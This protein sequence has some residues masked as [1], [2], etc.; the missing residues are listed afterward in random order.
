LRLD[1]P[2]DPQRPSL[3]TPLRQQPAR[4][5]SLAIRVKGDAAAYAPRL[6]DVVRSID[7]DTPAYWVRTYAQVIREATFDTRLLAGLFAAFGMLALVLAA[8][9][10]Y[11]VIAFNI[12]QRTREIGVRRALGA[13]SVSVLRGVLARTGWQLGVGIAG[14]LALGIALTRVLENALHGIPGTPGAGSVLGVLAALVV[15]LLA[16][17]VAVI[18]PA[19]RALRI[20]PMVALRHE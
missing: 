20:D 5:V 3:L 8:A 2:S 17:A 18:L 14:G 11:G 16:A 10:L 13:S 19:R 6:V 1:S 7:A 15:L 12:S 9:G 4:F